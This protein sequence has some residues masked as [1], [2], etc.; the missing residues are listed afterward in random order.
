MQSHCWLVEQ[1]VSVVCVV[2]GRAG[3]S[4]AGRLREMVGVCGGRIDDV[5]VDAAAIASRLSELR[6]CVV[7]VLCSVISATVPKLGPMKLPVFFLTGR[8]L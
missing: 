2:A 7:S 8:V 6:S 5:V 3:C 1:S 4:M